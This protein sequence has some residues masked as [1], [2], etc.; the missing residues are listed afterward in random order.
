MANISL[1]VTENGCIAQFGPVLLGNGTAQLKV[2]DNEAVQLPAG[3]N[4]FL[5]VS[6]QDNSGNNYQ[7]ASS[8]FAIL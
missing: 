1:C 6:G 3:S 7:F 4:Y 5:R 8:E 2:D